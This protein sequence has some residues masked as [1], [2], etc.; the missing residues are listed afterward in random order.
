MTRCKGFS[1]LLKSNRFVRKIHI[2][3]LWNAI[4]YQTLWPV[5]VLYMQS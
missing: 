4:E 5:G 2:C 3:L 1:E